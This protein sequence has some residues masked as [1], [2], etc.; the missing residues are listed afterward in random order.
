V[1][2]TPNPSAIPPTW[3]PTPY[4]TENPLNDSLKIEVEIQMPS[5]H[6]SPGSSCYCNV[7]VYNKEGHDLN[8]YPLVVILAIG[9]SYFFAPSFNSA[10]D[11]YLNKYPVILKGD[12]IIQV[13]PEFTWPTG[14]GSFEGANWYA[15]LINAEMTAFVGTWDG[16]TFGWSE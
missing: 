1:T 4:P 10:F 14:R 15:G 8:G 5:D 2:N 12:T 13:L 3:T 11:T 9:N 16:F 7:V 6:Y